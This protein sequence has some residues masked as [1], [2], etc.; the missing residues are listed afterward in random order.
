[1]SIQSEN[2]GPL[3]LE[4]GLEVWP[5]RNPF[6]IT[7]YTFTHID[8]VRVKVSRDG[9]VGQGE[10]A[11][12]YYKS[13][14]PIR[15]VQQI[16]AVRA[17]VEKGISI[18]ELQQL[19]PAGGARNALDCALWDLAAK[20]AK[21]P[22]Y[23]LAELAAPRPLVTTF[24]CPAEPPQLVAST[25][26]GYSQARAL[27]L[28]LTGE[29]VDADRVRAVREACA[30]AWLSIDGNQGFT[31]KSLEALLPVLVEAR[32][33]LIE[34]P[35][36]IGRD[37]ELHGFSSPIPLAADE[38]VQTREEI[39]LLAGR[40]SV[41]NIKLDKCGGM[42]EALAMVGRAADLGLTCM[43]GNMLGT[44]LAMAPAYLI[45]QSCRVVDLDGPI[46]LRKDRSE[47]VS[48][49]GGLIECPKSLW[50]YP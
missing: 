3:S 11:G 43:V 45:G 50:G 18:S 15:M 4:V 31:R 10:A 29:V 25:A 48:Y 32:V 34:Q 40:Y 27:K 30:D 33:A 7:G 1:M 24:T 17:K 8:T 41:V 46:F 26:R 23:A 19:L 6:Q 47:P 20:R 28:K 13:D 14:T 37:D 36:P 2:P 12:V 42:T 16:E 9:W 49:A 21:T 35:L 38:S 39:P 5:L 22:V 44:S